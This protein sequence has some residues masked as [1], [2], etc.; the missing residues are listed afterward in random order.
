MKYCE[1]ARSDLARINLELSRL[2]FKSEYKFD[3]HYVKDGSDYE[4]I[5]NYAKYL[6]DRELFGAR[7]NQ[8][9]LEEADKYDEEEVKK[10]EGEMRSIINR[11]IEKNGKD[12]IEHFADYRNYM[13]YE[14]LLT[15]DA[16]K[17]ARLSRQSGYN[18][19]AEVQ[20]PYLLILL[21][22]LLMI[23]NDKTSSTRLVFIDEPFAK[24]DPSNI[25]IMMGFMKQQNLQMIFC[26]P[27]KTELIGS[28]CDVI[29]PVLRTRIDL[30]E[31]GS[32]EMKA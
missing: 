30:M 7:G 19:G 31:M 12:E 4:K 11:I 13:N 22:A 27:D 25:R 2:H 1:T 18:S 16:L 28:E 6:K 15:N 17:K 10:M 21:S 32:I 5:L 23:Y 14:I 9:T 20:I 3:V 24:M 29:L 8:M 26:A